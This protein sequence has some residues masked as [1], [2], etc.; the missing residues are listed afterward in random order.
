MATALAG[1]IAATAGSA[2]ASA[3]PSTKILMCVGGLAGTAGGTSTVV[4]AYLPT[5]GKAVF[6]VGAGVASIGSGLLSV[7]VG[8]LP[9]SSDELAYGPYQTVEECNSTRN[10]LLPGTVH[11]YLRWSISNCFSPNVPAK[12]NQGWLDTGKWYFFLT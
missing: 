5:T 7:V 4:G 12:F 11:P 6:A 2:P 9:Q 3:D 1:T 10:D 8:C